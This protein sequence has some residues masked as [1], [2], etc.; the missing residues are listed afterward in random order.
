MPERHRVPI[1]VH[2]RIGVG[3]GEHAL[4]GNLLHLERDH[5]RRL[6]FARRDAAKVTLRLLG[7]FLGLEVADQDQRDVLRRV[8]GLVKLIRLRLGNRGNVRGPSDHGP[9]V[10]MR[11]PKQRLERLGEFAQRR[12][13]GAHPALLVHHVALGVE[14]AEHRPQNPLRLHPHPQLE[15]VRRHGDVIGGHVRAGEGVHPRAAGGRVNA[16]ELILHQDFAMLDDQFVELFF[17]L[18]PA[19][20]LGFDLGQVLDFPAPPH[21]AHLRLLGAH[22]VADA[23]LLGHDLEILFVIL[24]ADGGRALE[25]HVLEQMRDAGDARPLVAR[26]DA[27]DPATRDG[28]FIRPLDHEQTHAVGQ[29]ALDHR[30]LLGAERTGPTKKKK[31]HR[32]ALQ[33]RLVDHAR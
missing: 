15:F 7:G 17:Q 13:L 14:L 12:G 16:V 9:A 3:L 10:G 24:R 18:L 1:D 5:V 33:N 29:R 8:V 20:R 23:F 6:L 19:R 4:L 26:A 30:D 2:L 32:G 25:H 27:R 11:F 28:R 21:R 31:R 22:Q